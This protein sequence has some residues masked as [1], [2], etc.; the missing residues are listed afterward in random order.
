MTGFSTAS[1]QL[2]YYTDAAALFDA[3]ATKHDSMLLESAD[4]ESKKNVQCL[5]VLDAALKVTC[6][7]QRVSVEV[8]TPTGHA[9]LER[10]E[11]QLSEYR[12][13]A[14]EFEFRSEERRVG[15]EWRCVGA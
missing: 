8:L 4:I 11:E 9:M 14:G 13:G 12:V 7:G 1:R 3:L 6:R 2:P 5:A 10:L 15:N